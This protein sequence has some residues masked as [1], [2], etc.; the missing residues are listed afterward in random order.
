MGV[1]IVLGGVAAYIFSDAITQ[2][3][4]NKLTNPGV[5]Q[6][7]F[8]LLDSAETC[9]DTTVERRH[10]LFYTGLEAQHTN[11]ITLTTNTITATEMN[12]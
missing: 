6:N 1:A 2:P 10:R 8:F 11:H 4:T 12:F 9:R 5:I 3:C 7:T